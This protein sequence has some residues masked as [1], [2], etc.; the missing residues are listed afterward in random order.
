MKKIIFALVALAS[1]LTAAPWISPDDLHLRADLQ[2]LGAEGVISVPLT[3][4]P[5]MWSGIANDLH[6]VSQHQ[7]SAAAAES[8]RRVR[9][10]MMQEI[11]NGASTSVSMSAGSANA[12]FQH[13]GSVNRDKLGSQVSAEFLSDRFAGNLS[14]QY[15]ADPR[16]DESFRLDDTY[17]AVVMGNWVVS[18]GQVAQWYGPGMDS[19]LLMSTN[20][21]PMPGVHLTRNQSQPFESKWLAWIGPWHLTTGVN[22]MNDE[23]RHVQDAL[24]YDIRITAKPLPQLEIG[25]SRAAQLCGEGRPCDFDV[26]KNMFTG[27][28]NTG[29]DGITPENQ[30]GNQTAGVDAKWSSIVAGVPYSIYVETMGEDSFTLSRFPPFRKVS[31]LFGFDFSYSVAGQQVTTFVE[32]S[33]TETDCQLQ[34]NCTYEHSV[35]RSGMR[36]NQR[37]LGSTYDNDAHTLTVGNIG[38][39]P[40]GNMWKL[41]LRWLDLNRDDSNRAEPGGNPVA[42]QAETNIQ[43]DGAYIMPLFGGRLEMTAEVSHSDPSDQSSSTDAELWSNWQ[44]RF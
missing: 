35:Y 20:A 34:Q 39:S 15:A 33:D 27:K 23:D 19:A 16:D 30:P 14:V 9:H 2:R 18:A 37:A 28:D 21:R 36:Y 1:P 3:T 41:N 5:L 29:V 17:L 40:N 38:F 32:Y 24:V 22:W 12:R 6:D 31:R 13:F 10:R 8:L 7:L 11:H 44:Y 26:W 25:V 43:L 4:Y 42:P